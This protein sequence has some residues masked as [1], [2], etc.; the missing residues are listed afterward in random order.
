VVIAGHSAAVLRA[1]A[2]A[3]QGGAKRTLLLPVSVPAHSSL[4]REAA[5]QLEARLAST[6]MREPQIRFLS[7]VDAAAHAHP[8]DIRALL[9][10]QLASPVRWTQTVRSLLGVAPVLIE[11]GPGK[12]L[13][14]MNRRIERGAICYALEDPDS[15][16][17]ALAST[18]APGPGAVRV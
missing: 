15:L 11:C 3:R 9:V 8:D 1:M 12:V 7:A 6:P 13:T 17:V 14:A 5:Q 2:V 4:M 18:S 10:R 16:A